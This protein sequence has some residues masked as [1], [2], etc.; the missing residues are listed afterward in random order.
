VAKRG[1]EGEE[2]RDMYEKML[3]LLDGSE[4]AE[5]VFEYA[6]QLAGRL[7]IDLELLHVVTPQEDEQLPMRRAYMEGMA[8]ALCAGAQEVSDSVSAD[9]AQSC[10]QARGSVVVGYPA[11]EILKYV[12]ENDIDLVM[13]STRGRS[14]TKAWDIGSVASKVIHAAK[15]PVWLVPS[16]LREE[17]VLDT[18]PKRPLVIPLSG[19]KLSEVAVPHAL[20]IARQRGAESEIVLLHVE[21]TQNIIFTREALEARE[22]EHARMAAYL[23]GVAASIRDQ[24]FAVRTEMLAGDPAETIIAYIKDNPPQL[25]AMATRG[26]RGLSKMVFGSV[27]E[28][29]IHL[30]KKTPMLLVSAVD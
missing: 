1:P 7:N 19:S 3:V 30:I 20:A 17:I 16:E 11:E 22:A 18:L 27:T 26:R 29:V 5:V 28:D 12:E 9:A 24:G 6:R 10:I 8:E 13:L 2:G 23:E 14:G 21:D 25:I 4:L 15:V